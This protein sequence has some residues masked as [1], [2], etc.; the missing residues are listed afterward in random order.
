MN[1]FIRRRPQNASDKRMDKTRN[2]RQEIERW[3]QNFTKPLEF[4][5]DKN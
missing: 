3:S 5:N 4:F 1:R 2:S